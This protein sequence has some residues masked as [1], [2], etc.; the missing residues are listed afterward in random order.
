[1][2]IGTYKY[3]IS[4]LKN[5]PTTDENDNQV[6]NWQTFKTVWASTTGLTGKLFY[7]AAKSNSETDII[8]KCRYFEGITTDMRILYRG[9]IYKI[10]VPPLDLKG[11]QQ[12]LQITATILTLGS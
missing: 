1:M 8:F 6:D 9:D 10:K 4:F 5:S 3:K 2:E 7:E 12:E 11:K